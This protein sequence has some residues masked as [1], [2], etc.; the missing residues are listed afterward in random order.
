VIDPTGT[1]LLAANQDSGTVVAFRIDPNTGS[2]TPSGNVV[3][4]PAPVS[5]VFP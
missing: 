1:F 4:I 5:L 3:R 2:L